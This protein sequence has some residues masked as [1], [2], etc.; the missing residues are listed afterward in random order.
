MSSAEKARSVGSEIIIR[1][2]EL[3]IT[4]HYSSSRISREVGY[5]VSLISGV[6]CFVN[7]SLR[8]FWIYGQNFGQVGCCL[9]VQQSDARREIFQHLNQN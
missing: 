7:W 4:V 3:E 2:I 9:N 5:A 1:K 8:S 6:S